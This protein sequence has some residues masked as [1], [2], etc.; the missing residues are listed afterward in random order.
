MKSE[1]DFNSAKQELQ[2]LAVGGSLKDIYRLL[3]HIALLKY[4]TIEHLKK[5]H[6][7]ASKVATKPK[8]EKLSE[9]G[10]INSQFDIYTA[11][12]QTHEILKRIRIGKWDIDIDLLPGLPEGYGSINEL[13]NT[14][15]FIQALNLQDYYTLLYPNF[16]YLRPDAL[17][18]LKQEKRYRLAFLEIEAGKSNW[19]AWLDAKRYNYLKLAKDQRVF[20]YW[21]KT[22]PKLNLPVPMIDEFKFSV[23]IIGNITKQWGEGFNFYKKL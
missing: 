13:N 18:V 1:F 14:D 5:T 21:Q 11:T 4:S 8:L 15:V 2:A 22:A 7:T 16:S 10:F 6:K 20:E 23:S 19:D 17:L 9:L 3:Y 12:Q